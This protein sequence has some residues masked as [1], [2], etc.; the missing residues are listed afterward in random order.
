MQDF[1][2]DSLYL[3]SEMS[4]IIYLFAIRRLRVVWS[5]SSLNRALKRESVEDFS[6]LRK[7]RWGVIHCG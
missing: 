3:A 7:P 5:W 6:V 4:A 2:P 1:P